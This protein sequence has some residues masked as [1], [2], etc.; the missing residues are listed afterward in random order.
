VA[1]TATRWGRWS[2]W[3]PKATPLDGNGTPPNT[4]RILVVDSVAAAAG[5]AA[6]VSSNTSYIES[7][8]GVGNGAH[9][10]LASIVT[11]VCFLL[12]T[13]LAPLVAIVRYEAATRPWCSSGF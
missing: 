6:S 2:L 11:G 5:G 13:F 10:G 4:Q 7:A 8:A 1:S 3:A 12:A 9:T